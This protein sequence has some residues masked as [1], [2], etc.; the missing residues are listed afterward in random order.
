MFEAARTGGTLEGSLSS[1]DEDMLL[2]AAGTSERLVAELA[3]VDPEK[4]DFHNTYIIV[5]HTVW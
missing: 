5:T 3:N 4:E 1:V 2:V